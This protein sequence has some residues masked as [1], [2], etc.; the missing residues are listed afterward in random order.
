MAPALVNNDVPGVARPR[1]H[2][3]NGP[4]FGPRPAQSVKTS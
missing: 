1:K 3:E 4:T 2:A